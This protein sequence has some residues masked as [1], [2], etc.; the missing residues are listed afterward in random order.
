[1]W[2]GRSWTRVVANR[3]SIA[4]RSSSWRRMSP[5]QIGTQEMVSCVADQS[6]HAGGQVQRFSRHLPQ[7]ELNPRGLSDAVGHLQHLAD[8]KLGPARFRTGPTVV[9]KPNDPAV[10]WQSHDR[11]DGFRGEN[12]K[13]I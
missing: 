11:H 3:G 5:P 9:P 2:P 13:L 7:R 4:T 6:V 12:R 8:V 10:N 1:M